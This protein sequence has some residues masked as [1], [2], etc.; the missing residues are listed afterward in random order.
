MGNW[1][2]DGVRFAPIN[3]TY[4]KHSYC[5]K[6][7]WKIPQLIEPIPKP[8]STTIGCKVHGSAL[9]AKKVLNVLQHASEPFP[10]PALTTA[11]SLGLVTKQLLGW[12]PVLCA[13]SAKK[14]TSCVRRK[15]CERGKEEKAKY[16]Q[17]VVFYNKA[18]SQGFALLFKS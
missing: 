17:E 8:L 5:L 12:V 18:I 16:P 10:P 14:N 13:H 11:F 1:L 15:R 7:R 4:L 2:V 3:M 9:S 6:M